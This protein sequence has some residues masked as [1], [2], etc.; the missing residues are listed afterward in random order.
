[1]DTIL[2]KPSKD[3]YLR[4]IGLSL[5]QFHYLLLIIEN[6]IQV[7]HD[8]H[9][10]KKR[11][12]QSKHMT[13]EKKLLLTLTYLRHYPT[14][15]NLGDIFKISESYAHKIYHK[16]A[17]YLISVIHIEK[18]DSLSWDNVETV[19]IDAAEQ[20]IERAVK[21]QKGYYSGKKNDIQ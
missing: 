18:I 13:T 20:P 6:A 8:R 1:M 17:K 11:G 21:K 4:K 10:M 2:I 14:F 3:K 7:D 15:L 9:P 19:I 5:A 16:F 12:L